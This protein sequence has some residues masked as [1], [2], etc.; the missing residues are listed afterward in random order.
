MNLSFIN[1]HL[2]LQNLQ[3]GV[4]IHAEDTRILYA[5]PYALE[6]LRMTEEQAL[7]KQALTQEWNLI[8]ESGR[9]LLVD[10]YPVNRVLA[11]QQSVEGMVAGIVD[12]ANPEPTWVLINAYLDNEDMRHVIVTFANISETLSINFRKI[13]DLA[14]DIVV[15]TEAGPLNRIT[16]VNESFE[17]LTGHSVQEV[18]GQTPRILQGALTNRE[19]LDRVQAALTK[20]EPI[21]E[22]ILNYTKSGDPYWLDMNIN[23][24]KDHRGVVTHFVAIER[25]ATATHD[26]AIQLRDAAATDALTGLLNRRGFSDRAPGIILKAKNTGKPYSLIS[27]DFDFFKKVNDRFGHSEGDRLLQELARI[28]AVIFRKDDLCAR[29]GG[30]EFV[31]LLT[32]VDITETQIIAERLRQMVSDNIHTPDS[33]SVTISL[34]IAEHRADESLD[35]LIKRSD[36]ALYQAKAAGRNRVVCAPN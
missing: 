9:L 12:H 15:V 8:D 2:L 1:P 26:E 30:E 3:S 16:Y 18:I 35:I 20:G 13:V 6:L 14:N 25:D 4:V 23:P 5:N 31:I 10:E 28:M 22:V 24:I 17:K 33:V 29:F 27:V 21:R 19:T 32:S 34:G 7:G 36:Q 11:T